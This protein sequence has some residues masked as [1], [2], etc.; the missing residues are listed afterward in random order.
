MLPLRRTPRAKPPASPQ[1]LIEEVPLQRQQPLYSVYRKGI[2]VPLAPVLDLVSLSPLTAPT[3]AEQV[4]DSIVEAIASRRLASGERLI[5]TEL[6]EALTVSRVPVREAIRILTSQGIIVSYPRRGVRVAEF[7][8]A[9]ARQLHDARVAI[10]RL[11]AHLAASA[12]RADNG[13][14]ARLQGCIDEIVRARGDRLATNRADIA[15][16]TTLF[17]IAASPLMLTLW[18]AISRHVLILFSIETYRDIDFDRIVEEHRTYLDMLLHGTPAGIDEEVDQHV[19]G[20]K[21]FDQ[22]AVPDIAQADKDDKG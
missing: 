15:F 7:D 21:T 13:M 5:E 2:V 12:M 16:H 10:E 1:V 8:A 4:A 9:W 17:E 6:A 11:G 20:L 19:A 3:L 18:H 14:V 22:P